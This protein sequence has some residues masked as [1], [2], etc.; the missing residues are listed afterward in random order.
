MNTRTLIAGLLLITTTAAYPFGKEG[1]RAIAAAAEDR[2]PEAIK[3]KVKEVLGSQSMADASTWADELRN[4]K[5]ESDKEFLAKHANTYHWHFTRI[6]L[7][8]EGYSRHSAFANDY[9]V[10]HAID[11]CVAVLEG[12]SSTMRKDEALRWLIHLVGDIHQPLN[13]GTYYYKLL[14]N[15]LIDISGDPLETKGKQHDQGGNRLW[16]GAKRFDYI[17]NE[18]MVEAVVEHGQG[19]SLQQVIQKRIAKLN[20]QNSGDYHDW[21]VQWASDSL[22]AARKAYKGISYGE[23]RKRK[24]DWDYE[25]HIM[26]QLQPSPLAYEDS[27]VEVAKDQMAKASYRL[28]ELLKSIRWNDTMEAPKVASVET[29]KL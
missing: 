27:H 14:P 23:Y 28:A 10:V 9:D 24:T 16:I 17:W 7:N 2:L 26:V 4:S 12:R 20:V 3:V 5:N 6:P 18:R 21:P 29:E 22:V 19:A 11:N 25:W 1:H 13:V 15:H 8:S